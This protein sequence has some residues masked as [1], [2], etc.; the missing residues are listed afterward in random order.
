MTPADTAA[1]GFDSCKDP[2]L[3]TEWFLF[4]LVHSAQ[5]L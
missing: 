2:D 5:V 1:E 3:G 4:P